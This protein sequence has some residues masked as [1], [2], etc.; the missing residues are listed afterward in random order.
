[1]L[2]KHADTDAV[3]GTTVLAVACE[4]TDWPWSH[5]AR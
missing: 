4:D 3:L 1:M 2:A 5:L